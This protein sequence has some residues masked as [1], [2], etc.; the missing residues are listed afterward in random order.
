MK[1]IKDSNRVT[2]KYMKSSDKK[3]NSPNIQE[4]QLNCELIYNVLNEVFLIISNKINWK[5]EL[6]K[7]YQLLETRSL[8]NVND[9]L[10]GALEIILANK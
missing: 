8:S 2:N 6:N 5:E 9:V 3:N 1:F 4:C 10:N 7:Y